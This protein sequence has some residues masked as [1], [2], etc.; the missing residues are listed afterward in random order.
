MENNLKF[1][2][3][4]QATLM[5][6]VKE[7]L[8]YHH[9]AYR[10]EQT[11]CQWVTRYLRFYGGCTHPRDLDARAVEKFLSHLAVEGKVASSTQ[12]QALNALVFLYREVI[13]LPLEGKIAP[14]RGRRKTNLPTVLTGQEVIKLFGQMHGVHSLMAQLLYG[15]GLRL[16]ECLRLRIKDVDFGIGKIYVRN[17]KGGK[18]R[19]TYLP[20]EIKSELEHQVKQVRAQHHRDLQEGFGQV[21]IPSALSRKYS[22]ACRELGWQYVFPA[23]KKSIDPRSKGVR[24]HHVHESGLQKAVKQAC[25]RAGIEKHATCHTLRHSFATHL[26][27]NGQNIRMVQKLMGHADVKTTEIY[28]HVMQDSFDASKSPLDLL[29][30]EG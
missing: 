29:K 7:V 4:S 13:Q 1:T 21:Y 14:S 17:G 3:D 11:Y 18:D 26:L 16:T 5:S 6:Q 12:H 8:R 20:G 24:R 22:N 2:P 28:T 27:E 30:I 10:T 9:Y 19:I 25:R 23:K 15:S